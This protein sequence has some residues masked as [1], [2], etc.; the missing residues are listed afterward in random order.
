M[1][2]AKTPAETA[3][4]LLQ[5]LKKGK[6]VHDAFAR[7]F[8]DNYEISGR[9]IKEWEDEFKITVPPD[10]NPAVCKVIDMQIMSLHQDAAFYHAT[11]NIYVQALKKGNETEYRSRYAAL[12]AEFKRDNPGSKLPAR[13]TLEDLTRAET[14]DIEGALSNAE[15]QENFWKNIMNHLNMCRR[16]LENATINSGI[17]VKMDNH[18]KGNMYDTPNRNN[19]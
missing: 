14:D 15:L 19:R 3:A 4:S 7:N 2:E 17:E 5:T 9:T 6:A 18:H 11:A 8:R 12:V 10:P 13:G 16:L 1:T